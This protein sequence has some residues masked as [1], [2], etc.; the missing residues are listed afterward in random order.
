MLYNKDI[1]IT[2]STF[3]SLGEKNVCVDWWL[4]KILD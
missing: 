1:L 3:L 4:E 2:F